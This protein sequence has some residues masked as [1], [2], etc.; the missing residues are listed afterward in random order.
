MSFEKGYKCLIVLVER[1]T[2]TL[3]D[4]EYDWAFAFWG[5]WNLRLE[6]RLTGKN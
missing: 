4:V 1:G 2:Q 6:F 3:K 5:F